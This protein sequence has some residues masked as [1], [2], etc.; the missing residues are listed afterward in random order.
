M[1][2]R[3]CPDCRA[4]IYADQCAEHACAMLVLRRR[5][6]TLEAQVKSLQMAGE[7]KIP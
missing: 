7:K 5:I 4:F 3:L 1:T 2:A 6:E